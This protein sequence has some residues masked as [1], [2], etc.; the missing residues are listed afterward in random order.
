MR[1]DGTG[2]VPGGSGQRLRAAVQLLGG[3]DRRLP[4][5]RARSVRVCIPTRPTPATSE[6]RWAPR[7]GAPLPHPHRD[8]AH[9][10][11]I[12]AHR[13][14][15]PPIPSLS[16][17]PDM[18]HPCHIR[19]RTPLATPTPALAIT[20]GASPAPLLPLLPIRIR[21]RIAEIPGPT[22][23]RPDES[24]FHFGRHRPVRRP[25]CAGQ[26]CWPSSGFFCCNNVR[27]GSGS[28]L[29]HAV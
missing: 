8:W 9:P 24:D 14:W 1:R 20:L 25:S 22:T 5:V 19:P 2:A 27:N 13:D 11:A 21:I 6:P 12:S 7:L 29:A 10:P 17:H 26:V 3:S 18:P 15:V 28:T 16:L 4:L 23:L